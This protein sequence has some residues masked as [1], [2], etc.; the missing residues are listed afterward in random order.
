MTSSLANSCYG[1]FW[2]EKLVIVNSVDVRLLQRKF[3]F[4]QRI[5]SLAKFRFFFVVETYGPDSSFHLELFHF[6]FGKYSCNDSE[7]SPSTLTS[8]FLYSTM[9][10]LL[11]VGT[12]DNIASEID[13][14]II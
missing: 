3:S 2:D 14:T 7:P 6:F 5:L 1:L 4:S 13:S 11:S 10:I 12:I 8:L 9:I